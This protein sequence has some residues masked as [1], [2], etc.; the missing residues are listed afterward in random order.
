MKILLDHG[1]D[2]NKKDVLGNTPLHLGLYRDTKLIFVL[3]ID[4]DIYK[5]FNQQLSLIYLFQVT[6]GLGH[7]IHPEHLH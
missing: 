2:V 6:T 4:I 3:D 5:C 1:A 7:L